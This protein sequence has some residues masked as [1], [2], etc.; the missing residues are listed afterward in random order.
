M[1]DE[2]GD[3]PD[4]H[5]QNGRHRSDQTELVQ[6]LIDALDQLSSKRPHD[7]PVHNI[8]ICATRYSLHRFCHAVKAKG[9]FEGS[10]SF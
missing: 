7:E 2:D 3:L 1:K 8:E 10:I 4:I 9:E 5:R 6:F